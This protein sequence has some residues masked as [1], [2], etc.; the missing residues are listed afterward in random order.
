MTSSTD[1]LEKEFG[2]NV[3][4][5]SPFPLMHGLKQIDED[6]YPSDI[7]PIKF[8]QNLKLTHRFQFKGIITF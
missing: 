5:V 8:K 6:F 2:E 3:C 1:T 4:G 7:N